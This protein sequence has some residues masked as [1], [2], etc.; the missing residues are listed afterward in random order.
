MKQRSS[1]HRIREHICSGLVPF[2]ALGGDLPVLRAHLS[3]NRYQSF[4]RHPLIAQYRLRHQL[5]RVLGKA[6]VAHPGE[7]ELALDDPKRVLYLG[8]FAGL[9]LFRLFAQSTSGCLFL[10]LALARADGHLPLHA[11]G[12]GSLGHTLVAR[13]SQY[14][15]LISMQQRMALGHIMDVGSRTDNAV[16]QSTVRVDANVRLHP[17]VPLVALLDQVH[18]GV[19]FPLAVLGRTGCGNQG[20]IYHRAGLEH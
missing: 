6:L 5:G 13:I 17:E 7:V 19:T 18:L 16:F 1:L 14:N 12:F 15:L 8:S 9:E 4:A 20:G 3:P 11:H 2:Q 10:R